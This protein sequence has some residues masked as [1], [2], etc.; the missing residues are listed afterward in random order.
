MANVLELVEVRGNVY[1]VIALSR[2]LVLKILLAQ[3]EEGIMRVQFLGGLVALQN[4]ASRQ[5]LAQRNFLYN[6]VNI[7]PDLVLCQK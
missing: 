6:N 4:K 5:P 3:F 7:S 1:Q 2:L